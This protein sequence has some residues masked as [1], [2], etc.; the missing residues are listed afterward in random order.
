MKRIIKNDGREIPPADSPYV[1]LWRTGESRMFCV[2]PM[3]GGVRRH[4]L[5]TLDGVT[6]WRESC[7]CDADTLGEKIAL[8]RFEGNKLRALVRP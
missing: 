2:R 1:E 3:G 6:E 8:A 5:E 7:N 4:V